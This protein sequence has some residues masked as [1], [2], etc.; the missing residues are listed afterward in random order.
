M[1]TSTRTNACETTDRHGTTQMQEI[2]H[3]RGRTTIGR[4]RTSDTALPQRAE[5][6]HRHRAAQVAEISARHRRANPAQAEYGHGA[7]TCER[8]FAHDIELPRC[9]KSITDRLVDRTHAGQTMY[10]G[11]GTNAGETTNRHGTTQMQEIQHGRGRTTS[12]E[13]EHGHSAA[14]ACIAAQSTDRAT[15]R[16]TK[17][18]TRRGR[19]APS[20]AEH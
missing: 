12:A 6:A 17:S 1:Y 9:K 3:G 7:A 8:N 11:T 15:C 19:A 16:C 18:N 14:A 5:T 13:P 20:N 2:Q 10:A 4:A